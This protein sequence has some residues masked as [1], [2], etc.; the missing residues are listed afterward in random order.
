MPQMMN[1][2]NITQHIILHIF[3]VEQLTEECLT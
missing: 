2:I 3:F 1:S